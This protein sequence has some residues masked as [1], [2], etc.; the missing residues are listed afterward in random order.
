[1]FR[2]FFASLVG[3][4]Y[5]ELNRMKRELNGQSKKN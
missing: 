3:V 1:M 4:R 5:N 2:G